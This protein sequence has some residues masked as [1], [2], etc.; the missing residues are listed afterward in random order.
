MLDVFRPRIRLE[1]RAY[2]EYVIR[3]F[4]ASD[5]PPKALANFGEATPGENGSTS[6]V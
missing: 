4:I 5:A 3:V 2:F 6:F 1:M